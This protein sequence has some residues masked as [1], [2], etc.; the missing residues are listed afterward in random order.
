MNIREKLLFVWLLVAMVASFLLTNFWNCAVY[1]IQKM[2]VF[3]LLPLVIS[4]I[5]SGIAGI[6]WFG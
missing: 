6:S 3:G 2:V 4:K 5:A 1:A